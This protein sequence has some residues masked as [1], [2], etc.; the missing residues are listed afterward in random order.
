MREVPRGNMYFLRSLCQYLLPGSKVEGRRAH[1]PFS[2]V[3]VHACA[4]MYVRVQALCFLQ[5]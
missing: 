2:L 4:D 1:I 5:M 3:S